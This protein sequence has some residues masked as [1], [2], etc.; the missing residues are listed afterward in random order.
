MVSE[1]RISTD[2]MKVESVQSMETSKYVKH[3]WHFLG[4]TGFYRKFINK[5]ADINRQDKNKKWGWT[6]YCTNAVNVLEINS[7]RKQ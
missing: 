1:K 3:L 6:D 5:F 4:V 2:T 7:P